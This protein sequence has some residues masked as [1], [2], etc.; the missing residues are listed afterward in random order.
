MEIL[1]R[2]YMIKN[3]IN[4]TFWCL[5]DDSG[6]TGGLLGYDFSTWDDDKYGL[7]EP[8]LW[9]TSKSGK[10]ISLDHATPLGGAGSTTGITVADYYANYASSEGSNLAA[11]GSTA[12]VEPTPVE[13]NPPVE[14]TE[15]A[16]E[17][18]TEPAPVATETVPPTSVQPSFMGM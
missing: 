10:Y 11:G 6:D 13:T 18:S 16:P 7:F 14:T 5:N 8:S 12:P 2:N 15:P 3:H 17:P 9:Q 4:H 1:L